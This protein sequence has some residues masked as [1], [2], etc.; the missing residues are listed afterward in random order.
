[1]KRNG[2]LAL[3]ISGVSLLACIKATFKSTGE[4]PHD[5]GGNGTPTTPGGNDTSGGTAHAT[6]NGGTATG[7]S[8]NNT[9]GSLAEPAAGER[10]IPAAAAIEFVAIP[11]A[12]EGCVVTATAHAAENTTYEQEVDSVLGKTLVRIEKNQNGFVMPIVWVNVPSATVETLVA[13]LKKGEA[14]RVSDD[15]AC[16]ADTTVLTIGHIDFFPDPTLGSTLEIKNTSAGA[17][18]RAIYAYE[19]GSFSWKISY[20]T[21]LDDVALQL[22][23]ETVSWNLFNRKTHAYL[24]IWTEVPRSSLQ[25][26]D[27]EVSESL[28]LHRLL[29]NQAYLDLVFKAGD[30]QYVMPIGTFCLKAG[31]RVF[32]DLTNDGKKCND[33]KD[34][35]LPQ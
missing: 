27:I 32:R 19:P 7:T 17:S 26:G 33:V 20:T 13:R 16:T 35:D 11:S 25:T 3:A 8:D 6:G 28:E 21:T 10:A 5:D 31:N 15:R 2:F 22:A 23:P 34:T 24:G 29:P 12:G 30:R 9:T 1:M 4:T 18:F 14:V